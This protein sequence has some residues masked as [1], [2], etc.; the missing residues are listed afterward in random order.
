MKGGG[1]RVK[2]HPPHMVG[3]VGLG[4]CRLVQADEE[5]RV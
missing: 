3:I 5:Q 1:V 4:L 2:G